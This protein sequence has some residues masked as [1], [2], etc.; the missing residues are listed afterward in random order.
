MALVEASDP[1]W[2]L[3][4]LEGPLAFPVRKPQPDIGEV[5]GLAA[6]ARSVPLPD[7]V[8]RS[9]S[10]RPRR[11]CRSP[12]TG[13][14]QGAGKGTLARSGNRGEGGGAEPGGDTPSPA[15]GHNPRP[16]WPVSQHPLAPT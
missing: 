4:S 3:G 10:R 2:G 11:R 7:S 16:R 12:G 13:L 15:P 9:R 14:Q 6:P 8:A 1:H 5:P